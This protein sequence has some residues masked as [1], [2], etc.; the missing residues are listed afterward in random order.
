MYPDADAPALA[1]AQPWSD[2]QEAPTLLG[3]MPHGLTVPQA[4]E[5][6]ISSSLLQ[7]RKLGSLV[8]LVVTS[9]SCRSWQRIGDWKGPGVEMPKFPLVLLP[10]SSP[11][12]AV[13]V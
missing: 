1:P 5:T 8:E 7:R 2:E 9:P 13:L 12:P 6:K 4:L 3:T 11:L 10:P